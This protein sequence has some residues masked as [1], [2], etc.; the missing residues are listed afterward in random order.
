MCGTAHYLAPEVIVRKGYNK[1]AD[2][3]TVGILLYELVVGAPPFNDRSQSRVM[4]DILTREF[5]ARE[6]MSKNLK[7]LLF[8]LLEKT[9]K[10]RLGHSQYGGV[11]SIKNHEFFSGIDWQKVLNKEYKPPVKPNVKD[12]SDTK[13]IDKI[14]LKQEIKNTPEGSFSYTL[15]NKMNFD[16]FTYSETASIGNMSFKD[17]GSIIEMRTS[18][19]FK[20][21]N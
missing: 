5:Q 15:L 18:N 6:Y 1:M 21:S 20:L 4:N 7:K 3:W 16:N 8:G 9:P 13:N 19:D 2:W 11:Q 10:N 17:S 14:Y 12:H